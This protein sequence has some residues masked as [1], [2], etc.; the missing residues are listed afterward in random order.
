MQDKKEEKTHNIQEPISKDTIYKPLRYKKETREKMFQVI[1]PENY[2]KLMADT[3]LQIQE[4]QR[5]LDRLNAKNKKKIPHI[6]VLYSNS[7]G[8]KTKRMKAA[9]IHEL[10]SLRPFCLCLLSVPLLFHNCCL[11]QTIKALSIPILSIL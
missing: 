11:T 10:E 6:G 7:R 3:K 4:A 9:L 1:I 8:P 2:P 5:T